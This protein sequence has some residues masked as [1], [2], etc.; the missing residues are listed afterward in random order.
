MNVKFFKIVISVFVMIIS[1]SCSNDEES[2]SVQSTTPN[3]VN[4]SIE[5]M[6]MDSGGIVKANYKILMF[7][8]QPSPSLPL[9]TILSE[10][11]TVANGWTHFDL[12]TIVTST[13]PTNYC[14]YAFVS[15]G[16]GGYIWKTAIPLPAIA[17]VKGSTTNS[18]I[19]IVN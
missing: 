8:T 17:L 7:S 9:P 5:V 10:V 1:I 11:T 19:L 2:A 6:A 13:I 16:A 12:T 3:V 15:D 14:F 4:T 18:L